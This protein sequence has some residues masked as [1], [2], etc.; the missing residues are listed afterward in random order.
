M[1]VAVAAVCGAAFVGAIEPTVAGADSLSQTFTAPGGF[2][3]KAPPYAVR[4]SIT[5][6]GASGSDGSS[7]ALG[8]N[9]GGT[10]GLG[11]VITGQVDVVGGESFG[12]FIGAA[13]AELPGAAGDG[14]GGSGGAGGQFTLFDGFGDNPNVPGFE[15]VAQ[16]GGGGGGGGGAFFGQ[17]GGNG[18]EAQFGFPTNGNGA[19]GS[20]VGGGAGGLHDPIASDCLP[21]NVRRAAE[22]RCPRQRRRRRRLVRRRVLSRPGK[23]RRHGW[24][25]RRGRRGGNGEIANVQ[26]PNITLAAAPGGGLVRIDFTE[27]PTAPQITSAGSL[28][29]MSTDDTVGFAGD[30]DGLAGARASRC[31][32]RRRG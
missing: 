20:G 24:G 1:T 27:G 9:L 32:A 25:R 11:T 30:G 28:S 7:S 16:G 4:A 8:T 29:V 31:Q 17:A 21:R 22:T 5:V 14:A 19:A 6:Q 15:V 23:L 3:L 13:G 26:A 2:S 12:G 18:G 10:G